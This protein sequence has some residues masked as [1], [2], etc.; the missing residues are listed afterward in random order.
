MA[1]FISTSRNALMSLGVHVD[2]EGLHFSN[3]SPNAIL[4]SCQQSDSNLRRR[5]F[6]PSLPQNLEQN[7]FLPL[8]ALRVSSASNTINILPEN[9]RHVNGVHVNLESSLKNFMKTERNTL[10]QLHRDIRQPSFRAS[11]LAVVM[12]DEI[13]HVNKK[14]VRMLPQ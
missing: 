1:G 10:C 3:H 2:D 8:R 5:F 9:F 6:S 13:C 7:N 14:L 11:R 12:L 4:R